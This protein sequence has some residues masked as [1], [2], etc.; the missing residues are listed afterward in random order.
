MS[1]HAADVEEIH[2]DIEHQ[3]GHSWFF[4]PED[5]RVVAQGGKVIL[6]GTVR[7]DR[8]RRMAGAAAWAHEGVTDVA[9]ELIVVEP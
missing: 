3:L 8:E 5:I 6:T 1:E 7:S 2:D 9:N 4:N